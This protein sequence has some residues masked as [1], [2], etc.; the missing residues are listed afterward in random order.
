VLEAINRLP[1]SRDQWNEA[2]DGRIGSS[3]NSEMPATQQQTVGKTTVFIAAETI[4]VRSLGRYRVRTW[5]R[6]RARLGTRG[7]PC[8][9]L[10]RST[11]YDAHSSEFTKLGRIPVLKARLNADLHMT[12]DL[13]NTGKGNLFVILGEPDIDILRADNGHVRVKVKGVDVF[14]PNTRSR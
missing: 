8:R 4:W 12:D 3:T 2:E 7:S 1:E 5:W 6:R 9:S 10:A 14:H 13:K 11:N